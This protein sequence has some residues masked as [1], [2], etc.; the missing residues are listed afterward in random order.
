MALSPCGFGEALRLDPGIHTV[1]ADN[2]AGPFKVTNLQLAGTVPPV[3]APREVAVTQWGIDNRALTVAAGPAAII[4]VH[5]NYNPGWVATV[6]GHELRAVRL[7]GWQQG[8]VLPAADASEGVTLRFV[9]DGSFRAGLIAGAVIALALVAWAALTTRRSKNQGGLRSAMSRTDAS[10]MSERT[11]FVTASGGRARRGLHNALWTVAITLI[12]FVVAGP[13]ALFV[14]V[15]I[16]LGLLARRHRAV[17]AWVA[18]GAEVLAG[19]VIAVHPGYRMG[20]LIG[21][22]SY[23]AQTLGAL[24]LAALAVSLLPCFDAPAEA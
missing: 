6:G 1:T 24:A 8:W 18:G 3:S 5:E 11:H 2:V 22:G 20:V 9:P 21:S 15:C 14:P 4:N 23:T 12:V 17:L 13:A 19:I 16:G 10:T 7:D